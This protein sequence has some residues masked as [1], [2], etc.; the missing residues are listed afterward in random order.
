MTAVTTATN[1]DLMSGMRGIAR[2]NEK[3]AKNL[4]PQRNTVSLQRKKEKP[5]VRVHPRHPVQLWVDNAEEYEPDLSSR[6][7]LVSLLFDPRG[8]NRAF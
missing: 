1:S 7:G 8:S 2:R 5:S 6:L 3:A 4:W